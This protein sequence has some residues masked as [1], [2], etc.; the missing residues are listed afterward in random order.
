MKK[1]LILVISFIFFLSNNIFAVIDRF[2]LDGIVKLYWIRLN[3]GFDKTTTRVL[4]T[5]IKLYDDLDEHAFTFF[6][7]GFNIFAMSDISFT[8]RLSKKDILWASHDNYFN[9][10]HT[11]SLN[12]FFGETSE[13]LKRPNH[14]GVK[15]DRLYVK[16]ENIMGGYVN[17]I[18][19]RQLYAGTVYEEADSFKD[20]TRD[21][22]IYLSSD[23]LVFNI[24]GWD[25]LFFTPQMKTEV[26]AFKINELSAELYAPTGGY[27][28]ERKYGD[29][30]IN[31]YGLINRLIYKNHNIK[32]YFIIYSKGGK[33]LVEGDDNMYG[34][35]TRY[36][37]GLSYVVNPKAFSKYIKLSLEGGYMFGNKAVGTYYGLDTNLNW[38]EENYYDEAKYNSFIY[39]AGIEYK[40]TKFTGSVF[41]VGGSGDDPSTPDVIEGFSGFNEAFHTRVYG[42]EG[43][44]DGYGEIFKA[45]PYQHNFVYGSPLIEEDERFVDPSLCYYPAGTIGLFVS[46]NLASESDKEN[47]IIP[48]AEYFYY[49]V[50]PGYKVIA[51]DKS[52]EKYKVNNLG[53]E[54]DLSCK[55]IYKNKFIIK[56]IYG[57]YFPGNAF[58]SGYNNIIQ[59]EAGKD[60]VELIKFQ[61]DLYF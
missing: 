31:L 37:I 54:I 12:D 51:M 27:L 41:N 44:Y 25:F 57:I 60:P 9:S 33:K 32:N 26:F 48:C 30:D 18:G 11:Q 43:D 40:S 6:S 56:L 4:S 13:A 45:N 23:G 52:N 61:T 59:K 47:K 5:G 38:V 3:N 1:S 15:V 2:E 20:I 22:F 29:G 19:G 36:I 21:L 58:A 28:W 39:R 8:I 7:L 35:D 53:M 14:Y 50:L 16:A 17:F 49:Y 24:N 42:T 10:E 46:Y 34:Y 55:Y